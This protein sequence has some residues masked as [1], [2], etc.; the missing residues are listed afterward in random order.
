M[1]FTYTHNVIYMY[2]QCYLHVHSMLFYNYQ[3][4]CQAVG[5]NCWFNYVHLLYG[6]LYCLTEHDP[7]PP[8]HTHTPTHRLTG[9][10]ASKVSRSNDTNQELNHSLSL[11]TILCTLHH[12]H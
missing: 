5:L 7:P 6:F 9:V 1:L 4:C 3:F 10:Q 12:F 2:T 8:T 11:S